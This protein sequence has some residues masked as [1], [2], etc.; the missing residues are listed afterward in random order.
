[1]APRIA[2]V[3]STGN[4]PDI[5]ELLDLSTEATGGASNVFL[6][7]AKNPELF[8]GFV[9]FSGEL[10][11]DGRLPPVKRELLI[12]RT[13]WLCQCDYEWGQHVRIGGAAGLTDEDITRVADELDPQAWS[14]LGYA[15][16][17]ATDELVENHRVERLT[18]DAL[19][20][21]FDERCLVELVM[22]V[23]TYVALAGVLNSA[24]VE[25]EPGVPGFPARR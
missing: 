13:A 21:Q 17:R 23:G 22:V 11:I 10:L 8:R 24:E 1:M 5:Q 12:L 3:P 18:W 9:A 19:A 20:D 16:L 6:T 7:L 14:P 25:R 4:R 15:L 2:P